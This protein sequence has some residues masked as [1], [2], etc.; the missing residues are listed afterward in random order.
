[1]ALM[2]IFPRASL[3]FALVAAPLTSCATIMV[4]NTSTIE[5]TSTPTGAVITSSTGLEAVTPCDLVLPNGREVELTATHDAHPG[6]Q[7]KRSS[8]PD[9]SRWA[10]GNVIFGGA[11][12]LASDAANP[13]ARVHKGDIHFDFTRTVE[14][15]EAIDAAKAAA[16]AAAKKRSGGTM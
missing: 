9:T 13:Q 15:L 16:K 7:R 14:E 12:G 11:A 4:G 10:A 1:M 5:V 3:A 6:D 8:V 2:H